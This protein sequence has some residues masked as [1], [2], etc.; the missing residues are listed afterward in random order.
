[1]SATAADTVLLEDRRA[2]L[3]QRVETVTQA[4]AAF[5][6]VAAALAGLP[7]RGP[8]GT[9]LAVAELLA[10]ALLVGAIV[11]EVLPRRRET[12]EAHGIGWV[13]VFAAAALFAEVYHGAQ[14]DGRFSRPTFVMALVALAVGLA[15]PWIARRRA[16]MRL[17][18]ADD[19]GV[20]YRSSRLRGFR[21][22]WDEIAAVE[23]DGPGIVLRTTAGAS[24]RIPLGRF[25]N[26]EE[27]A[28]LLLERAAR[29]GIPGPPAVEEL[30]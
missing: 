23:R 16:A 11:R 3:A 1:M 22:R 14:T 7:A 19:R 8:A 4:G 18:R 9:A 20:E 17:V 6:L 24:R 10:A 25:R 30:P 5:S 27:A 29:R 13:S 21:L 26:G 28:A 2:E 12:E 15:N